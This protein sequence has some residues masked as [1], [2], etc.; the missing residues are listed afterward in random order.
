LIGSLDKKELSK[1]YIRI[2]LLQLAHLKVKEY[3]IGKIK[4]FE[5]F[6]SD[7]NNRLLNIDPDVYQFIRHIS[8]TSLL[9]WADEAK[10][11]SD[12]DTSSKLCKSNSNKIDITL[13]VERIID[14]VLRLSENITAQRLHSHL[15]TL[16][17]GVKIS[18]ISYLKR[19]IETRCF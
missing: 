5:R 13:K 12:N 3:A 8:C 19:K 2:G 1:P 4:G 17:P 11:L 9:R 7:Y 6:S 14:D 18:D 15:R 10:A 16:L